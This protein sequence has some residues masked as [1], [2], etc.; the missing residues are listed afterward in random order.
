MEIRNKFRKFQD[1]GE[2]NAPDD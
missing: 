2:V 1:G